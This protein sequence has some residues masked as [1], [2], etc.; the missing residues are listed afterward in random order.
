MKLFFGLF[1]IC[2]LSANTF[3]Q[4]NNFT[5][6][7]LWEISGN[8]LTEPSYILGTIHLIEQDKFIVKPAVD[9][10]FQL[11]DKVFFEIKLDDMSIMTTM[12]H[13]STFTNGKTLHNYCTE[14]EYELMSKFFKD[15]MHLNLADYAN[16][17]PFVLNQMLLPL[18]M[19]EQMASF[20]IHFLQK[21]M[22]QQKPISGLETISDQLN[23]FDSIPYE[24]QIDW[25]VESI[26]KPDEG[27]NIMDS[28]SYYYNNGNLDGLSDVI[29][30]GSNEIKEYR[31]LLLDNRNNNWIPVIEKAM[32][33]NVCFFAM[34]AGHLTGNQGVLE[35]L[36]K[37]GYTI[38]PL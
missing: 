25:L 31:N 36:A 22:M 33:E 30:N 18:M 5:G 20:E 26:N 16:Q 7:M 9:S 17:K 12:Q 2:F 32:A 28:M 19:K 34:G 29:I 37:Q 6:S 4:N 13:W 1:T 38:K 35:L 8:G 11:A 21:A 23:I 24:K 10:A 3:A 15:S 14:A 27:K